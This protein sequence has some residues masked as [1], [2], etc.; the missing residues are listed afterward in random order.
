MEFA[1]NLGGVNCIAKIVARAIRNECNQFLIRRNESA[2]KVPR[3][4]FIHEDTQGT[5][6]FDILEFMIAPD[7]IGFTDTPLSDNAI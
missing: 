6:Q 7:V 5:N 1:L 3:D 2:F 4:E